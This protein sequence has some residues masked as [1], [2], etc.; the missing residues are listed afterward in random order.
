MSINNAI[1]NI[2]LV[3]LVE[4]EPCK[5]EQF[6]AILIELKYLTALDSLACGLDGS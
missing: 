5:K 4:S 1:C 2:T 3:F 6:L